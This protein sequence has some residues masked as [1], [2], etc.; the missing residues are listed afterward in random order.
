MW[1]QCRARFAVCWCCLLHAR[2]M[3]W[4]I[5]KTSRLVD[6]QA[7]YA[8]THLKHSSQLAKRSARLSSFFVFKILSEF[9]TK[10]N[11]VDW[12]LGGK[13]VERRR[14]GMCVTK[15]RRREIGSSAGDVCENCVV[16]ERRC[17]HEE[18]LRFIHSFAKACDMVRSNSTASAICC[19]CLF[20]AI[21]CTLNRLSLMQKYK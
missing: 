11:P 7:G 1:I 4:K 8:K 18:E 9:V 15:R 12:D 19:F 6:W 2:V 10:T 16:G 21:Y 20:I 13:Y 14:K 17:L 3:A 5:M